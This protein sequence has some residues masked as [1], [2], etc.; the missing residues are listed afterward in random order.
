M[1]KIL[2]VAGLTLGLSA[3]GVSPE[4][5][6]T[7]VDFSDSTPAISVIESAVKGNHQPCYEEPDSWEDLL[8]PPVP[9]GNCQ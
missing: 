3:C 5:P 1:R 6:P 7:A 8:A 9:T 4:N 2:A